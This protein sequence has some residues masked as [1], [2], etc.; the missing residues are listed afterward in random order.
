MVLFMDYRSV[1]GGQETICIRVPKVFDWVIRQADTL[2]SV[3]ADDVF[4]CASGITVCDLGPNPTLTCFLSDANGNPVDPAAPGSIVCTEVIQPGGRETRTVQLPNGET[5]QL[6]KVKVL[7]EGFVA[8]TATGNGMT[9]HTTGIQFVIVEKFFLCAPP[10]T[11]VHCTI[12]DFECDASLIN[13]GAVASPSPAN[14]PL[15]EIH[16][17]MCQSIEMEADV[18]LE[19]IANFCMPRQELANACVVT[20]LPQCPAVFPPLGPTPTP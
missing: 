9:C 5:V 17:N 7:K 4:T 15:L 20:Q 12:T 11:T 13:C 19:I 14:P 6:Q 2:V 3:L 8:V 16:V 18:K 1:S 10:G